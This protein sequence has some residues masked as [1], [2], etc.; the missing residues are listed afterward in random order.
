MLE[1]HHAVVRRQ[2]VRFH[3]RE[4]DT[5]GDGFFASFDGPARAIRCACEIVEAVRTAVG[6]T[7]RA[8]VHTGECETVDGKIGG[9]AV[10]IGARVAREAG[11]GEVLASS[12]V[13]D[14]VA[15]SGI[16]FEDRG[17]YDLKGVPGEWRL[18]AVSSVD[19]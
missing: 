5:A 3:G 17:I 10:H 2:L 19:E 4:L 6:L 15:G 18:Y 13:K 14:L 12:T 9:I 7:V 16:A 11:P 1:A 8:G